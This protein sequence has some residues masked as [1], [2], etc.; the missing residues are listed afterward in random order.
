MALMFF[1]A[2]CGYGE[3]VG[4]PGKRREEALPRVGARARNRTAT[5]FLAIVSCPKPAARLFGGGSVSANV[6]F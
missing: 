4:K 5:V 3:D 6:R 2:Y 1:S